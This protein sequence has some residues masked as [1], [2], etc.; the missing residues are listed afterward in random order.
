[1][2]VPTLSH[3]CSWYTIL[4]FEVQWLKKIFSLREPW[5]TKKLR[6]STERDEAV[7]EHTDIV[8]HAVYGLSP[9][10]SHIII[11]HL[12]NES[13][14][15]VRSWISFAIVDHTNTRTLLEK[16]WVQVVHKVGQAV[17]ANDKQRRAHRNS[18]KYQWHSLPPPPP[19]FVKKG[20]FGAVSV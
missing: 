12:L 16:C 8:F 20:V 10:V 13:K 3:D 15:Q 18:P 19:R 1:M 9:A 11:L 2:L 17:K 4:Y 14:A 6:Y 5:I 7:R